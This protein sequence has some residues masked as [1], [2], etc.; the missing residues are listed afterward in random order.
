MTASVG[1]VRNEGI[2]INVGADIMATKLLHDT[3]LL[4]SHK[5]LL[6]L[7]WDIN[8]IKVLRFHRIYEDA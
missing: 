3:K 2:C 5:P 6:I 7:P 4:L 1:I 8:F